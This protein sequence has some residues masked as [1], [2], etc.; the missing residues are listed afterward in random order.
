MAGP[1]RPY[2]AINAVA[3][4]STLAVLNPITPLTFWGPPHFQASWRA[5]ATI[6]GSSF[7]RWSSACGS[8]MPHALRGCDLSVQLMVLELHAVVVNPA[9]PMPERMFQVATLNVRGAD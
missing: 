2:R 1:A 6:E 4:L 8:P 3:F 9:M 5:S 7:T